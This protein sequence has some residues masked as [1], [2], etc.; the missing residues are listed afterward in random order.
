MVTYYGIFAAGNHIVIYTDGSGIDGEV[1]A[2]AVTLFTPTVSEPS[3]A[4]DRRQIY[5]GPLIDYTV[6]SGDLIGVDLALDIM[7]A[8]PDERHVAIF[9]DGQAGIKAVESPR[10][11]SGQ[12]MLRQRDKGTC[13]NNCRAIIVYC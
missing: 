7:E 13:E 8:Y 6:Y 12:Y 10:Q 4:A 1:G 3:M 9:I 5:L 2:S 11:Q